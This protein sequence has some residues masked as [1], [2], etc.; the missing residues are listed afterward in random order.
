MGLPVSEYETARLP[1]LP[2]D[3]LFAVTL[4]CPTAT[5]DVA[6]IQLMAFM[7]TVVPPGP[8][9]NA[10]FSALRH[11]GYGKGPTAVHD[12]PES[13]SANAKRSNPFSLMTGV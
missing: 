3:D 7:V 10:P 6:D 2:V 8:S 5:H 4:S 11:S 13:T 12:P 1:P 9:Q